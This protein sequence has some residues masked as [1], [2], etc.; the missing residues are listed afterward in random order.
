M[1]L[2]YDV[3][4]M[5]HNF[6]DKSEFVLNTKNTLNIHRCML[7]L[8]ARTSPLRHPKDVN[9]ITQIYFRCFF[10]ICTTFIL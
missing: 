7:F 2:D 9:N 8:R 10:V 4:C 1:I 5:A 6:V 3:S